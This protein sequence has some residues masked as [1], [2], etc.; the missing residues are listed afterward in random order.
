MKVLPFL[1]WISAVVASPAHR[2]VS[3]VTWL[4]HP[5]LMRDSGVKNQI[6]GLLIYHIYLLYMCICMCI[7][8][9]SVVREERCTKITKEFIS[10]E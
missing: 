3:D 10:H 8:M 9:F 5:P 4:W 1:T 6:H 2:T 7:F